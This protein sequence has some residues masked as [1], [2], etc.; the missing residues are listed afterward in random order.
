MVVAPTITN[1]AC[2]STPGVTRCLVWLPTST[3][4]TAVAMMPDVVAR[5]QRL[6]ALRTSTFVRMS[7]TTQSR[8][9]CRCRVSKPAPVLIPKAQARM[10][11]TTPAATTENHGKPVRAPARVSHMAKFLVKHQHVVATT[12]P[13][14]ERVQRQQRGQLRRQQDRRTVLA[15]LSAARTTEH[16]LFS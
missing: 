6:P 11:T 13:V 15:D 10:M 12:A 3:S 8:N 14:L 9:V 7:M 5:K 2:A 1:A 16:Y 4:A